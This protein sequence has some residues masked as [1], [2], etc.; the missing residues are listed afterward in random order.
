LVGQVIQQVQFLVP[1]QDLLINVNEIM[2]Q[3]AKDRHPDLADAIEHLLSS[4]GKRIRPAVALLCGKMLG[5]PEDSLVTLAAAIELLHTAT[6]V[7]DDLI[8]GALFRR[9]NATINSKW[10]PAATVLTGDFIFACAANL[11]AE[12]NSVEVM[13]LF[14][15]TLAVIV[16]GE[17]T[18]LLNRNGFPSI[19]D[20]EKRIYAKTASMFE[21]A[22]AAAAILSPVDDHVVNVMHTFGINLGMAFQIVDDILDYTGEALSVGKPVGSDLRQ[23]IIT[24]PT[25]YFLE[26]Q[27][28]P[29][30]TRKILTQQIIDEEEVNLVVDAVRNSD[31]ID[32]SFDRAKEYIQ[33]S[34]KMLSTF[35]D[36]V[37]RQSLEFL[38]NFILERN[39]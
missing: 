2:R 21:L 4:G 19:E 17:I 15:E 38:L 7:H 34:Q 18:Q 22:A 12:T 33:A 11:A 29:Q 28:N 6:L 8:D 32:R 31:A 35:K 5:S 25:L 14:A 39:T 27:L 24:L 30:I 36:D 3:Q 23:G 37:Y 20:Y 13:K 1:V 26:S 10:T 9:G 16:N